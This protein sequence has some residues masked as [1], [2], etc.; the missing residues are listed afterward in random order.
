MMEKAEFLRRLVTTCASALL[1][2]VAELF[3]L[4]L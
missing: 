1:D 3:E 2:D 4:A